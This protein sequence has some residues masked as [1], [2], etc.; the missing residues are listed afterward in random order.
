MTNHEQWC[1]AKAFEHSDAAKRTRDHYELH[2]MAV[3]LECIGKWFAV[4][5]IDGSSDGVLYDGKQD[6]VR[7]QHH[8]EMYYA[9]V[10]INPGGMS[11][12]EA[13]A[14]LKIHRDMYDAGVRLHDPAHPQGGHSLIPALSAEDQR[15]MRSSIRSRG[16]THPSGLLL[17]GDR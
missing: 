11:I 7:H 6:A 13:E 1:R 12:C 4:A 8:N 16:R 9:Y 10:Q 2:R 14:F 15:S 3:P 5:L 17:P